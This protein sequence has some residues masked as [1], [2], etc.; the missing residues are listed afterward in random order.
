[1]GVNVCVFAG[2]L[3]KDPKLVSEKLAVFSLPVTSGWGENE[4]TTW[5]ECKLLGGKAKLAEYLQKGSPVTVA[6]ELTHRKYES[7]GQQG[8]SIELI[9]NDIQLPPK[10]Q[11]QGYQQQ[12]NPPSRQAPQGG[13][14]SQQ[15]TSPPAQN[16]Y[17]G[18]NPPQ[19]PPQ[20]FDDQ[21]PF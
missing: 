6:G 20:Q 19:Q 7:N 13:Y 1:M 12:G 8:V 11:G 2:N 5:V 16:G 18:N 21:V 15:P 4:V 9:V 14:Q 3:G 10:Q 17:G